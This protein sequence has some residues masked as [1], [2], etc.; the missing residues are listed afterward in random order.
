MRKMASALV[1]AMTIGGAAPAWAGTV[2]TATSP[3]GGDALRRPP[4]DG[5]DDGDSGDDDEL[6]ICPTEAWAIPIEI[7]GLACILLLPRG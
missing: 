4:G 2:D 5:S 7:E 1:L 6:D 3:L